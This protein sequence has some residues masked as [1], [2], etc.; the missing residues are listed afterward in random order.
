MNSQVAITEFVSR[1]NQGFAGFSDDGVF[2]RSSSGNQGQFENGVWDSP[3]RLSFS[4]VPDGTA[5]SELLGKFTFQ[6]F[7]QFAERNTIEAIHRKCL[8]VLGRCRRR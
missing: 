8:P 6:C 2:S 3:S 1:D 7:P 5:V 4:F